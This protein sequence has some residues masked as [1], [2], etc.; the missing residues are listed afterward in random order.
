MPY[1]DRMTEVRNKGNYEQWIKFFL[2]A[3]AES[4]E[5]AIVTVNE[6]HKLHEKIMPSLKLSA[7]RKRIR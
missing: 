4:A 6:L 3:V 2:R 1:Y 7:G 5:D